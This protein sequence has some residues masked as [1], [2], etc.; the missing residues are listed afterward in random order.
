MLSCYAVIAIRI[1]L[2]FQ[3]Y[4]MIGKKKTTYNG[5]SKGL[6]WHEVTIVRTT[7][8]K[9]ESQ[10][11]TPWSTTALLLDSMWLKTGRVLESNQYRRQCLALSP[12]YAAAGGGGSTSSLGILPH[13]VCFRFRAWNPSHEHS[14]FCLNPAGRQHPE[15]H[16]G[17]TLISLWLRGPCLVA[18]KPVPLRTTE[19][20]LKWQLPEYI[21]TPIK[22]Q[23]ALFLYFQ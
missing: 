6:S 3:G 7:E 12:A 15:S 18:R 8:V 4:R 16:H 5:H 14:H 23:G 10:S 2:S 22:Q 20:T 19:S 21:L 9:E 1:G 13:I 11:W 17:E